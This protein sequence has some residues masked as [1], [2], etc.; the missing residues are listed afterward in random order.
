MTA[1][2]GDLRDESLDG[3][4]VVLGGIVTGVRSVMTKA[5]ATMAVVTLEDLQGTLEV[6]V[7]PKTYETTMGTWRDGAI[8]L[9]AGRVDHRGD[10]ASLL[11]DSVWDWDAAEERGP[12]AFA[13]EVG[14]L[15]KRARRGRR[16]GPGRR[17]ERRS[18]NGRPNGGSRRER[19]LPGGRQ[20]PHRPRPSRPT[21]SPR[22]W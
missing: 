14:S 12:E 18:G 20:Q 11:A 17:A 15:D 21:R 3:Q 19:R 13:R 4:R 8:L 1:Y 10:E 7:F 9:V 6:V 22:T 16:R 2:S 5:R